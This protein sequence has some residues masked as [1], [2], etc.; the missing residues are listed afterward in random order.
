MPGRSAPA[1][2]HFPDSSLTQNHIT[3][4]GFLWVV[5]DS[6][7]D[8]IL[9]FSDCFHA[10]TRQRRAE[11]QEGDLHPNQEGGAPLC[12]YAVPSPPPILFALGQHVALG[13]HSIAQQSPCP[14]VGNTHQ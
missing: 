1:E 8:S 3:H 5:G 9:P 6:L 12:R 2:H 11:E 10:G 7:I 14:G 4:V 13:L